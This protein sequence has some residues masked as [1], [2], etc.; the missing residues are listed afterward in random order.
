MTVVVEAA[1]PQRQPDH[2]RVRPGPWPRRSRPCPGTS[3][4]R[5]PPGPNGL[6]RGRRLPGHRAAT[7]ST[8]SSASGARPRCR[9]PPR[10]R[11]AAEPRACWKPSRRRAGCDEIGGRGSGLAPRDVRAALGRL[12]AGGLSSAAASAAGS[13]SRT[14]G[15]P[16]A[17]PILSARWRRRRQRLPRVLSIAGSDSGGGAGIQADLK[18]FAALRRAR[19]DARSPRS[20]RRTRSRSRRVCRCRRRRSSRRSGRW[21]RT[22]AWTPSRSACSAPPRRSRRSRGARP[23]RRRAGVLDPVMVAESGARLLDERRASGAARAAAAARD[24]GHAEPAGGAR[25]LAGLGPDAPTRTSLARAVHALGPARRG[26]HRRS[27]RGRRAT[28]SSTASGSWRSPASGIPAAPRTARAARTPP[29]SP[30]TSR[31]GYEP[32]E[33]ARARQAIAAEAVRDGLREI[34]DGAGPVDVL[35]RPRPAPPSAADAARGPAGRRPPWHNQSRRRGGRPHSARLEQR[36]SSC[37]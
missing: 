25:L 24:R 15:E 37:A 13:E 29:R 16:T 28:S 11:A 26:R 22:S 1:D 32:L 5:S 9:L 17:L 3:P 36:S 30:R 34:G 33:A 7:C 23:A 12:E 14:C 31:S 18:A 27:P 35:G 8:S 10:R 6:L 4:R 20:P 2:G 21:S 19:D